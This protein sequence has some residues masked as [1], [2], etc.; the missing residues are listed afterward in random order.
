ASLAAKTLKHTCA[1]D[2]LNEK[3]CR[4]WCLPSRFKQ[5]DFDLKDESRTGDSKLSILSNWKL[6]L[7]EIKSNL[8]YWRTEQ[9]LSRKPPYGHIY[10]YDYIYREMKRLKGQLARNEQATACD[11]LCSTAFSWTELQAPK[12]R[13]SIITDSDEKWCLLYNS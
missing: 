12:L 4:R 6:P 2:V 11:L 7:M 13:H 3:T 8:H 5:D 10:I 9:N 1:T